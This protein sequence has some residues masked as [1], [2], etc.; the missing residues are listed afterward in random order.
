M[1]TG[2]CC[3]KKKKLTKQFIHPCMLIINFNISDLYTHQ[4]LI[5][6]H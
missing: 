5:V 2:A 6:I 1:T 4:I 3:F